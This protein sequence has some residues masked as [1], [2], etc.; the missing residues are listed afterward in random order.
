MK[1]IQQTLKI[2]LALLL[3]IPFLSGCWDRLDPENMAFIVAVG[4]DPGP[5]N[6]YLFTFAI[7]VPKPL[8]VSGPS[9]GGI[10]HKTIVTHTVEGSNIISALLASQSFIARRLTLTHSKVFILGEDLAR[11]GVMPVLGEVVRSREFRRSFYVMTTRGKAE[12]YIHNIIPTTET[13]ISLWFELEL[14]PNNMGAVLPRESRFHNF[15]IDMEKPGT[16]AI[17]IQTAPRPDIRKGT[18]SF[19]SGD[20]NSE[21]KQSP[22]ANQ[23]AGKIRR[24]GDTPVEFFGS[25]VYK[26]DKLR[27]FL[28]GAESRILNMLRGEYTRTTWDIPDPSN[29]KLNLTIDMKAQTKSEM[30][31]KRKKDK[32]LVAF[33]VAME[34]DLISVQSQVDFTK[35]KNRKKLE[36]AV[37]KQL[38]EQSKKVLDKTLHKWK[39][40]CFHI[41][42]RVKSTFSTLKEWDAYKWEDH[43]KDVEYKLEI[44]FKMRGHG[45][46]VGPAIGGNKIHD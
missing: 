33:R 28:T 38:E 20:E 3:C 7:A 40:D 2:F 9:S 30:K 25:A 45:D 17:S 43:V 27:G 8:G 1:R 22:I 39:V 15:I 29:N 21:A 46:Q 10:G 6:D 24:T 13:D 32:V 37:Q 41:N 44:T 34:G 11:K 19:P 18:A 36:Q 4:V 5:K 12:T 42:N 23:N 35:P 31:I 26:S 14:D 16:G